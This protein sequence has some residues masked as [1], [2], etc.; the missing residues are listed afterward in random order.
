MMIYMVHPQHG[1]MHVYAET[2]ALANEKN[3]WVRMEAT[4]ESHE[5]QSVVAPEVPPALPIKRGPGR[6]KRE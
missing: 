1:A 5:A 4:N 3:G 2:E 6:P